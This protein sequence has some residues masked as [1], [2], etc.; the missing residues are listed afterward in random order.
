[1]LTENNQQN[2]IFRPSI[3]QQQSTKETLG[4]DTESVTDDNIE[5]E[6]QI[7]PNALQGILSNTGI[8]VWKQW[9]IEGVSKQVSVQWVRDGKSA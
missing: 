4:C 7:D 1:M 9:L 2:K 5:D 8:E 3:L 6:F